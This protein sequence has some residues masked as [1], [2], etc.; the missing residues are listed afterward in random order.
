MELLEI[1]NILK[2]DIPLHYREDF[3][4]IAVFSD[5]RFS[6]NLEIPVDFSLEH[7]ALGGKD[8]VVNIK[9]EDLDYPLLP[10]KKTIRQ[11]ILDLD[12]ERK[13]R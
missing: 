13:I 6:E 5:K 11:Y 9:K 4:C 10:I 12:K 8:V 1:R 7:N 2:K 3:S